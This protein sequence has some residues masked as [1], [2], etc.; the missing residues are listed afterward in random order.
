MNKTLKTITLLAAFSTVITIFSCKKFIEE[1]LVT[2]LTEDYYK[3]DAGLE[4][5]VKSAY[6][7]LKWLFEGEQFSFTVKCIHFAD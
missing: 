7:P 2:T 5:L 6:V 1:E 4:D 3:T